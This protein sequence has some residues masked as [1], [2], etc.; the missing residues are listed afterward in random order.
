M[1]QQRNMFP[2]KEQDKIP[3]ELSKVETGNLPDKEFKAMIIKMLSELGRRM[4]NTVRR[5]TKS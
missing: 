3:E 4:M 2:V 1:R 5:L